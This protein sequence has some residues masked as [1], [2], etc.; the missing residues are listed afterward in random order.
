MSMHL[1]FLDD[2]RPRACTLEQDG[3]RW[4][5]TLDEGEPWTA[6]PDAQGAVDLLVDGHRR[7]ACSRSEEVEGRLA[8]VL[9]AGLASRHVAPACDRPALRKT[10][11]RVDGRVPSNRGSLAKAPVVAKEN[12]ERRPHRPGGQGT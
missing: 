5:V 2:D 4:T 3:D 11:P 6:V 10:T 12:L 7:R 9:I 1:E 8:S